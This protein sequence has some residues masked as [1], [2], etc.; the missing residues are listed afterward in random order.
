MI[1]FFIESNGKKSM[2][3]YFL[4][5]H[6]YAVLYLPY[7]DILPGLPDLGVTARVALVDSQESASRRGVCFELLP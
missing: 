7:F 3:M 2:S 1:F 6:R 4:Y 5:Y